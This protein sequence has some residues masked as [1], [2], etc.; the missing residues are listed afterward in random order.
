MVMNVGV[1]QMVDFPTRGSNTL[2]LFLSNRPSL[3]NRCTALP[4]I[5]DHDIVFI[6]SGITPLRVRPR[7]RKVFLWNNAK[8][9]D[10]REECSAFQHAFLS[11][12]SMESLIEDM[13]ADIKSTL[14]QLQERFVPSKTSSSRFN[15]PWINVNVRRLTIR[16]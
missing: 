13:W 11:K 16:K 6:D 5:G 1:Q 14:L 3:I 12:Y 2:D 9:Q 8:T 7:K 4:G 15:Q 10:M